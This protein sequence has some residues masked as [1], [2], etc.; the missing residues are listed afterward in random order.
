[1]QFYSLCFIATVESPL[2]C[3]LLLMNETSMNRI[4]RRIF[5]EKLVAFCGT[6]RTELLQQLSSPEE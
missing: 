5:S 1:M 2:H 3:A 6:G 4:L